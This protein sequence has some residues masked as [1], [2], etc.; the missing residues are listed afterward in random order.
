MNLGLERRKWMR[1]AR[2]I[3][4]VLCGLGG[5]A[6]AADAQPAT[7][8]VLTRSNASAASAAP[9]TQTADEEL[10]RRVTAALHAQPYLEDRHIN[11]SVHGGTVEV[12][13]FVY[14]LADLV[15]AVQTATASAGGVP[16]VNRLWIER[17]PRH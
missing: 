17:E 8:A 1:V 12:S 9:G 6:S 15:D 14:S 13:G 2:A 16:V 4:L 11:V 7:N 3:P 5:L 10:R